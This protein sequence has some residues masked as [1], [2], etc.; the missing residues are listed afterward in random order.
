MGQPKAGVDLWMML[1]LDGTGNNIP[2]RTALNAL[3]KQNGVF[4]FRTEEF[5]LGSSI[6]GPNN[7]AMTMT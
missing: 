1:N 3:L 5:G 6:K 4:G 2:Y 7:K